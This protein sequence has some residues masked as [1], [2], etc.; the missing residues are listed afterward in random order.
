MEYMHELKN[1]LC[2]ELEK[3]VSE[4]ELTAGSLETV[5]KLTHSIKSI[6]TIMAME[7]EGYSEEGGSY[8]RGGQ[9]SRRG[10]SRRN[11]RDGGSYRQGGQSSRRGSYRQGGSYDGGSYRRMSRTDE[12]EMLVEKLEKM[13]QKVEDP[14]ARQALE[15]AVEA[16]EM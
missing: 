14:N 15:E 1:M 6:A 16:M 4:G 13:M 12:T 7:D 8:R 9:G 3:I 5:D 10:G 2:E 11:Y